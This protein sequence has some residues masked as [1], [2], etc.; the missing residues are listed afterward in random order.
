MQ[1][2]DTAIHRGSS[3]SRTF[4]KCSGRYTVPGNSAWQIKNRA[5]S[6]VPSNLADALNPSTQHA[7]FYHKRAN[8]HFAIEFD[9]F[10]RVGDA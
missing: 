10:A 8:R 7:A 6:S 9:T 2:I 4:L 5:H 3:A 1:S